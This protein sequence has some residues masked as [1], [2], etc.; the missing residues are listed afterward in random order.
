MKYSFIS[1]VYNEAGNVAK[2]H[3]ELVKVAKTLNSSYEIIFVDDG[4]TDNTSS[5]LA[6][7]SPLTLIQLRKNFGQTAA[8][9]AGIKNA[10]GDIIVTLDSDL[11]N[12]PQDIPQLIQKLDKDNLDVV[13]GWRKNRQDPTSKK[14]I[15]Q[16]AKYL[17]SLL[18]RDGVQ[19]AG[20]TLRVYRSQCFDNLDLR[21]EMHRFIPAL[22]SWRGF[23]IGELPVNH[24]PRIH[25]QS[26]Y[27]LKRT[28]KGFLDMLSIW[29]FRKFS[30]RP[31][32]FLGSVG[33]ISFAL[34][35]I[36]FT[37][38]GIGR[39]L[40][41]FSLAGS[42]F[43]LLAVFLMLFGIQMFVAGLTMDLI[44]SASSQTHYYIKEIRRQ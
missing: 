30:G 28:L 41:W 19:D 18:V 11:Q 44:I 26:K 7:L 27:T 9:D 20:C 32:H 29:F 8:L 40:G 35:S 15:S 17:R 42:I 36:L 3:R 38:L 16:G 4:S 12:D 33:L 5:E 21:G 2:L 13:C 31:L 10:T 22:L 1:P 25:G 24:R 14:I 39:L 43:P 23:K 37:Y 34:G 6:K